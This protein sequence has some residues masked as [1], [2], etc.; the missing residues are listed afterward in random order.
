MTSSCQISFLL[1]FKYFN[2]N[3]VQP[4]IIKSFKNDKFH[5]SHLVYLSDNGENVNRFCFSFFFSQ[6]VLFDEVMILLEG[7]NVRQSVPFNK[8][9]ILGV[10]HLHSN[11]HYMLIKILE[12]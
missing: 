1:N 10:V 12:N 2:F 9:S 7:E 6:L 11:D 3:C 5:I 8:T 4:K